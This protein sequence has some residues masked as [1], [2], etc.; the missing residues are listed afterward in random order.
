MCSHGISAQYSIEGFTKQPYVLFNISC[1]DST[2]K[3]GLD[4]MGEFLN[5]MRFEDGDNLKTLFRGYQ[6]NFR[7][8]VLESPID[9][10]VSTA[11]SLILEIPG[12]QG[13]LVQGLEAYKFTE[14]YL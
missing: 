11:V 2:L 1:L 14:D 6:S 10:A 4:L 9:Y 13:K 12:H 8:D 3:A 5:S 7:N